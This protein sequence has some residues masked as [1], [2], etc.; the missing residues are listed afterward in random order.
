M[1][2]WLPNRITGPKA[3]HAVALLL[4]V[5]ILIT[6]LAAQPTLNLNSSPSFDFGAD[7][8]ADPLFSPSLVGLT[9]GQASFAKADA[10][11]SF[12]T[13]VS[14]NFPAGLEVFIAYWRNP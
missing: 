11:R 12:A 3:F 9:A 13:S 1:K 2:S 10:V 7:P 6:S 5:R 8:A 4:A 14:S